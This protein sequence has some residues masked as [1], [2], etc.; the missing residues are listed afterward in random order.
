MMIQTPTKRA[1][2]NFEPN[3]STDPS[4]LIEVQDQARFELGKRPWLAPKIYDHRCVNAF[5]KA[6][7]IYALGFIF[8]ML[9]DFWTVIIKIHMEDSLFVHPKDERIKLILQKIDQWM[10]LPDLESKQSAT[11]IWLFFIDME[12]ICVIF[13]SVI[14]MS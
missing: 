6:N 10:K 7:D 14:L 3:A 9:I 5:T 4:A 8:E 11:E 2:L 13:R 12:I 1:S